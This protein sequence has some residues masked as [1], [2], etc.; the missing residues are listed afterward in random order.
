M[1]DVGCHPGAVPL[2]GGRMEGLEQAKRGEARVPNWG[3][4]N[5][6]NLGDGV[7]G[8]EAVEKG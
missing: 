8:L 4:L 5:G 2:R 3:V 1:V 6:D 7:T